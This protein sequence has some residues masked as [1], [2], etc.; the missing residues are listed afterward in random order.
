M[1][2]V[3]SLRCVCMIV[4]VCVWVIGDHVCVSVYYVYA[5]M[6]LMRLATTNVYSVLGC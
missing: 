5:H 1:Y 2:G 3:R 4:C 6:V